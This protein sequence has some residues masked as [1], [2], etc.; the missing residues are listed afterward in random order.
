VS[1]IGVNKCEKT[2]L[3][4]L[5]GA[6]DANIA[7]DDLCRLMV[8]LGFTQ[9]TKGSHHIFSKGGVREII[10][11]QP[12]GNGKSKKYQVRQVRNLIQIYATEE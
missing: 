4:V 3:Q 12:D 6:S 1:N 2:K 7:F 9:R 11:L 5:S 10:N 8:H